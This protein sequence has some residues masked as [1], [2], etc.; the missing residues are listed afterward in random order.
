[1]FYL[2]LIVFAIIL[3]IALYI[4][5]WN[6]Q[7]KNIKSIPPI[8]FP[9]EQLIRVSTVNVR[10]ITH[11]QI[12]FHPQMIIKHLKEKQP[13]TFKRDLFNSY[14]S[15]A[16]KV[17]IN[18]QNQI[19]WLPKESA[20]KVAVHKYLQQNQKVLG[21]V[22]RVIEH[23]DFWGLDIDIAFYAPDGVDVSG[24]ENQLVNEVRNEPIFDEITDDV[25]KCY[26][27]CSCDPI[28]DVLREGIEKKCLEN[29]GRCYKTVA[30]SVKYIIIA[31][32]SL[33]TYERTMHWKD[34]G[35][36][37]TTIEDFTKYSNLL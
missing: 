24:V 29:G 6:I 3:G 11:Q 7:I 33:K 9:N 16:V 10:G 15:M 1:M 2:F 32:D 17:M 37:V 31:N 22:N 27:D 20:E 13:V 25:Y 14:D 26:I 30:K 4:L 8:E 28:H 19:G 23:N 35:F 5:I 12:G 34:K 36:K 21:R 18:N